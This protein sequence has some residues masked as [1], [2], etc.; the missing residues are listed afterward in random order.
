M[1]ASFFPEKKLF[2]SGAH[3]VHRD[4][5]TRDALLRCLQNA[6]YDCHL[7]RKLLR[8]GFHPGSRGFPSK[9]GFPRE[10]GSAEGGRTDGGCTVARSENAS[11]DKSDLLPVNKGA[12][13]IRAPAM[14]ILPAARDLVRR[15]SLRLIPTATPESQQE[16]R[17]A[18]MPLPRESEA[19]LSGSCPTGSTISSVPATVT[20]CDAPPLTTTRTAA[21]DSPVA[22][23]SYRRWKAPVGLRPGRQ[24]L[25]G[26]TSCTPRYQARDPTM[27][28]HTQGPTTDQLT[29]STPQPPTGNRQPATSSS[30]HEGGEMPQNSSFSVPEEHS[31]PGRM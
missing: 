1:F 11:Q 4:H 10:H 24:S 5:G 14:A 19:R 13:N 3:P 31:I 27:W 23:W 16:T 15:R 29:R 30:S 2:A 12:G 20:A 9:L 6:V 26:C 8:K 18:P 25:H 21:D 17:T 7:I 28:V 22:C